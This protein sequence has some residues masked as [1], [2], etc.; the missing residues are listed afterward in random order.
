M[1]VQDHVQSEHGLQAAPHHTEPP[2]L[3]GS[4]LSNR[5]SKKSGTGQ[6][7]IRSRSPGKSALS[8]LRSKAATSLKDGLPPSPRLEGM[9]QEEE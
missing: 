7:T 4:V 1:H 6:N 9:N 2:E 5:L 8:A 3:A